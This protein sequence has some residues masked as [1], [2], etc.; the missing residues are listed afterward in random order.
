MLYGDSFDKAYILAMVKDHREDL[1]TFR[2]EAAAGTEPE[3]KKA[4]KQ[5][6]QMVSAHLE[7]A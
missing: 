3:V 2:R 4:A 1:H 7:L 6:A 5:W